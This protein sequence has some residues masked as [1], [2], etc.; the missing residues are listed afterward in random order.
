M[1]VVPVSLSEQVIEALA[2]NELGFEDAVNAAIAKHYVQVTAP[3]THSCLAAPSACACAVCCVSDCV[4]VVLVVRSR[5]STIW[6]RSTPPSSSQPRTTRTS[7]GNNNSHTHTTTTKKTHAT[8]TCNQHARHNMC[9]TRMQH[10]TLAPLLCIARRLDV[11]VAS[12]SARQQVTNPCTACDRDPCTA[13]PPPA[14]RPCTASTCTGFW[15]WEA[16]RA[17]QG[18]RHK[19][20]GTRAA[21][22]RVHL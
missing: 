17:A 4:C 7:S 6:A 22:F 21:G 1:V 13:P 20:G 14:L 18:R 5:T 19:G 16:Q 12:R 2:I 9:N 10:K 3:R 15:G 8:Q 11:Q